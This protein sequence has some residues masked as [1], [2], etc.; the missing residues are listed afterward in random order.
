MAASRK[1]QKDIDKYEAKLFGPFTLRQ[2]IILAIGVV[3]VYLAYLAVSS[4]TE[5]MSFKVITCGIVFTPFALVAYWKPY[6]MTL[7]TYLKNYYEYHFLSTKERTINAPT[8]DTELDKAPVD[9]KESKKKPAVKKY[10]H[11]HDK[12]IKDYE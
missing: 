10:V 2:A 5:E 1:T 4:M 7:P 12:K 6:G 11:K 9:K 8:L 3:L